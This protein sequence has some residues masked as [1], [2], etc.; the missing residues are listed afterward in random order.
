MNTYVTLGLSNLPLCYR[1]NI[2]IFP[3]FICWNLIPS[4]VVFAN[5]TF[6]G[7]L[8]QEDEALMNG[9]SAFI[10]RTPG[11]LFVRS[12]MWA[13]SKKIAVYEPES[14]PSADTKSMSALM[15]NI[16]TSRTIRNKYLLCV[17]YPVYDT[18]VTAG[19]TV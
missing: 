7:W 19:W 13:H 6:G 12:T 14:R 5:G 17:R 16:S 11:S 3:K 15:W 2:C 10:K 18:S 9:F 4:L 8:G 1:L